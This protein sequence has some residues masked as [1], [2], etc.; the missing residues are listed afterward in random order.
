M[1]RT[2]HKG[3]GKRR[4]RNNKFPTRTHGQVRG[5]TQL[6]WTRPDQLETRA[7]RTKS[8][9]SRLAVACCILSHQR[10]DGKGP[11][12]CRATESQR[13]GGAESIFMLLSDTPVSWR[14]K[15]LAPCAMRN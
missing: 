2:I 1:T 9:R 12:R 8:R 5:D 14:L 6:C 4:E 3:D 13:G 7:G 10:I 11:T 15:P